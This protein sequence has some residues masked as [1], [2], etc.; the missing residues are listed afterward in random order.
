MTIRLGVL[1]SGAGTNLQAILDAIQAGA[2]DAR[3]AVVVSNVPGAP[4]LDRATAAGVPTLA[5]DHREHE[6]RESFD[7]ALVRA[8]R[9][10]EVEW[11]ILAGFM[12]IITPT[13]IDAFPNRVLN[14]HPALLPAFPG[15][16]APAQALEKGVKVTGCTVHIVDEGVDTGPILAQAAVP[17]LPG[18]D[19]ESLTARIQVE[20]RRL[21][22]MVIQWISEGRLDLETGK[23]VL[24][25]L[26]PAGGT[27]FSPPLPSIVASGREERA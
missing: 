12:R 23:P 18:D 13:F 9:K 7:A 16:S 21:F 22:P 10:H 15:T 26:P 25:G 2:L 3:V 4:A 8:L 24:K 14:I 19:E 11:V 27:L 17:V 6:S 5:I 1:A 20:E